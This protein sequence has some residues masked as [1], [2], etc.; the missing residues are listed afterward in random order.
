MLVMNVVKKYDVKGKYNIKVYMGNYNKKEFYSQMGEFFAER[1][2]RKELPYLIND[3]D[4]MWYLIYDRDKFLG[5]FGIKICTGNTLISDIYINDEKNK[6]EI[7]KYMA[8]YLVDTY[9]EE[10]LK[11]LTKISKE[12]AIWT[13]LGFKTVGVRGNYS[14]MIRKGSK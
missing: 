4:K 12:Q 3:T 9:H 1:I 8:N 5:F 7:F 6:I 13:K 10:E 2:Y 11:V 14:I